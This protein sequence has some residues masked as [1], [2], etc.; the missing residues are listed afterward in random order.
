MPSKL[1]ARRQN[2]VR[3]LQARVRYIGIPEKL[4]KARCDWGSKKVSEIHVQC[5]AFA[6]SFPFLPCFIL[7]R[8]MKGQIPAQSRSFKEVCT[9]PALQFTCSHHCDGC[10]GAVV[11]CR[12]WV[13][14]TD[15]A[16]QHSIFLG[17]RFSCGRCILVCSFGEG[18]GK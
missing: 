16:P 13:L 8:S 12:V 10:T 7:S 11:V 18:G 17:A 4:V 3:M 15:V 6:Y 5:M 2:R 14:S 9:R 1:L